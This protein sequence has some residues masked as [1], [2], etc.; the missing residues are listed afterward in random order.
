VKRAQ[1]ARRL[2]QLHHGGGRSRLHD[3]LRRYGGGTPTVP[4]AGSRRQEWELQLPAMSGRRSIAVAD[5]SSLPGLERSTGAPCPYVGATRRGTDS[6]L[7]KELRSCAHVSWKK[8]VWLEVFY[9][10][11]G[12]KREQIC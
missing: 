9:R 4:V 10:W 6:I 3:R 7:L 12:T 1:T 8:R 5:V 11:M 2:A